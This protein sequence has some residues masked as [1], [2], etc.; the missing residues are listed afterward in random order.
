VFLNDNKD[1]PKPTLP[2]IHQ[3]HLTHTAVHV[4]LFMQQVSTYDGSG[5]VDKRY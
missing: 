1:R 2:A 3:Q 5:I 4:Q